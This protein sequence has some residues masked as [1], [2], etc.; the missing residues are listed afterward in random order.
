MSYYVKNFCVPPFDLDTYYNP[1]RQLEAQAPEV[2]D[3]GFVVL[4][5]ILKNHP[6]NQEGFVLID[7]Q[8]AMNEVDVQ[9]I[10]LARRWNV[11]DAEITGYFGQ[12]TRSIGSFVNWWNRGWQGYAM[13]TLVDVLKYLYMLSP[14]AEQMKLVECSFEKIRE[15][16]QERGANPLDISRKVIEVMTKC[17]QESYH[18]AK[19]VKYSL[20]INAMKDV[21]KV[22]QDR[23]QNRLVV[24]F[25]E[26]IYTNNSDFCLFLRELFEILSPDDP[27]KS[28]R[29]DY[30]KVVILL[31]K[32]ALLA[33]EHRLPEGSIKEIYFQLLQVRWLGTSF[34]AHTQALVQE[35]TGDRENFTL[36]NASEKC[37]AMNQA[38]HQ[39]DSREVGKPLAALGIQCLK[40]ATG[41]QYFTKSNNI[42]MVVNVEEIS[43]GQEIIRYRAGSPTVGLSYY[44][45]L[46]KIASF[47]LVGKEDF[48]APNYRIFV[49][50]L[51]ERN[52]HILFTVHQ[53]PVGAK[54]EDE[55]G[56]VRA[57]QEFAAQNPNFHLLIQGVNPMGDDRYVVPSFKKGEKKSWQELGERLTQSLCHSSEDEYSVSGIYLPENFRERQWDFLAIWIKRNLFRGQTYFS[58]KEWLAFMMIFYELQKLIVKSEL[59]KEGVNLV[60]TTDP[61]KDDLDRGGAKWLTEMLLLGIS[62]GQIQDTKYLNYVIHTFLGRP[63]IVKK[64]GVVDKWAEAGQVVLEKLT[65]RSN[66][67]QIRNMMAE[68]EGELKVV[69][70]KFPQEVPELYLKPECARSIEEVETFWS[71][72]KNTFKTIIH[73][74]YLQEIFDGNFIHT[75]IEK[76]FHRMEVFIDSD[77]EPVAKE[78]AVEMVRAFFVDKYEDERQKIY[79]EEICTQTILTKACEQ[80]VELTPPG[81][82]YV[83]RAVKTYLTQDK[84]GATV[85]CEMYPRQVL[86]H[87]VRAHELKPIKVEVFAPFDPNRDGTVCFTYDP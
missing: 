35:F 56:R 16:I 47:G 21:F 51:N 36:A 55:S 54:F 64:I 22:S 13:D 27:N 29:E 80:M 4:E 67:T 60:A 26:T 72:K 75:G 32:I 28:Y 73:R 14:T 10:S 6:E 83:N 84:N 1:E 25:E 33:E 2:E 62:T 70:V 58:Q 65:D 78:N 71:K 23:A 57:I 79:L 59:L 30:S 24:D 5:K 37:L 11:Q 20:A 74:E 63:I 8:T 52:M 34:G 82:Q 17:V 86:E 42:P 85:S 66:F 48:I 40:G 38:I 19:E 61:C 45:G 81:I 87:G 12:I 53:T 68:I 43:N 76:D 15:E 46:M 50:M 7:L 69:N 3:E 77:E 31:D 49:Q 44:D 18:P 39:A 41:V 9:A